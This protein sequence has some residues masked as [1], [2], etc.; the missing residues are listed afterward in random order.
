LK[1]EPFAPYLARRS[2]AG[3][4]ALDLGGARSLPGAIVIPALAESA[5]LPALLDSLS[6]D[7]TLPESGLG[8]VF[9]VN[10]REDASAEENEDNLATLKLL[11]S[12]RDNLSFP[13]GIVD[14]ASPGL[15]LPLKDGGVGLA[16]KLGHDLLLPFLDFS[17][18]PVIVSL[19][20]DT[21][22][23]PG[24]S[25]AIM[26]HFRTNA[27]GG[28]VIP[29]RHRPGTGTAENRAIE[30]YELFL[31]CYVA[32]LSHAGSPYAFQTVGSAMACRASAYLKCGGM[33][34]RRAGEDFYFLQSL[35]K[36]SGVAVV[37]GTKVFPSPRRS[38]RVPFGTGRAMGM[39]LDKEP[40][41]VM[42]HRRESFQLLK[43]WL[44]LARTSS[45]ERCPDLC[46]R[47]E[48][49]SVSLGGFLK[50]QKFDAAWRGFLDQY[51]RGER[52]ESAFH[53]WFD[54]FRTMKLFH[55]L[56]ERDF[57][58]A[59]PEEV[60]GSFPGAWGGAGLSISERL[61]FLRGSHI[62]D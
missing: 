46:E 32:G 23:Q 56:A 55:Y 9:V 1:H 4:W 27:A 35:A 60:L 33:N 50:E 40:G 3:P 13:V 19:D 43:S 22:V 54:A 48:A 62:S 58:R 20:A 2:A 44:K 31:R 28:A 17:G 34:K 8:V 16:R 45:Q 61:E 25:G 21:L 10:N 49:L 51:A 26:N 39:L 38:A 11:K 15:E 6:A 53:G 52:I 42:F 18:D 41:A 24:Y 5:S 59:E 7:G 37:K 57:P 29:F 36:T 14:A 47:G 12:V 30:R